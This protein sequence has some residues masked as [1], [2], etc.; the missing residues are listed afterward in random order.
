MDVRPYQPQDRKAALAFAERIAREHPE[1]RF[2]VPDQV[3]DDYHSE[4][5]LVERLIVID[6]DGV[7]GGIGLR[8]DPFFIEDEK[9]SLGYY[10]YPLSEGII[11]RR[12]AFVA[13]QLQQ[14][15]RARA[16]YVYGMGGGGLQ[17][18]TMQVLLRSGWSGI[19]VPFYFQMNRPARCIEK[20]PMLQSSPLRKTIAR[21]AARSG[22]G[23]VGIKSVQQLRATRARRVLRAVRF[24]IVPEFGDWT[25]DLFARCRRQYRIIA[26]RRRDVLRKFYP[27]GSNL[28]RGVVYWQ[29][30]RIG[31]FV[32]IAPL[33]NKQNHFGELS[34]GLIAD[35]FAH[36]RHATKVV[37]A[38]TEWLKQQQVDLLVANASHT[39]WQTAF[40]QSGYFQ[41]P[42]NFPLVCSPELTERI[43]PL[44]ACLDS[45]HLTR[46]D[47]DGLESFMALEDSPQRTLAA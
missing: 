38:A 18:T 19:D 13:L 14:A 1:K 15:V 5:R 39:A 45:A 4:S 44:P 21:L 25:D 9:A 28:Q 35:F 42:S 22:L 36:P 43:G 27:E 29:G 23:W 2:P 32:T 20:M 3:Y 17:S 24:E 34:V 37:S 10:G 26:D 47:G 16:G 46:C 7:H 30:E 31:W 6:E 12:Y 8:Y 33:L 41:G 11:N 40:G